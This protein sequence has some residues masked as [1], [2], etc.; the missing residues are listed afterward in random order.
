MPERH[1]TDNNPRGDQVRQQAVYQMEHSARE[2][3]T[4]RHSVIAE[5]RTR[6]AQA[7]DIGMPKYMQLRKAILAS[8]ED[9]VLAPGDQIPPE[10]K[11]TSVLGI[12]LGTV[13]RALEHLAVGGFVTREHGRGTFVAQHQRAID[14]SWHYRFLAADGKTLLPVYSH[15]I[16]RDMIHDTGPWSNALGADPDGYVRIKR[17]FNVDRKFL[18]YSEFYLGATRFGGMMDLPLSSLESVNLKKVLNEKFG[19]PTVYVE[20]HLRVEQFSDEICEVVSV[21]KKTNGLF[22]EIVVHTFD[23]APISYHMIYIPPTEY[24]LDLSAHDLATRMAT[25]VTQA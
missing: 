6:F 21:D 4:A 25:K 15:V 24:R 13:R 2:D 17:C 18:S 9:N 11:L 3:A 7:A 23:S 1:G 8:I 5:I 20:Q 14:D 19:A 10:E 22:L 12:S 16:D